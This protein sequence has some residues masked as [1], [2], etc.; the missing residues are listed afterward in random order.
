LPDSCFRAILEAEPAALARRGE[1]EILDPR[2]GGEVLGRSLEG[3]ICPP[4]D[5]QND[6]LPTMNV[7]KAEFLE[8]TSRFMTNSPSFRAVK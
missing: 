8:S 4:M 7:L 2:G 3:E 5:Q 6:S 1:G